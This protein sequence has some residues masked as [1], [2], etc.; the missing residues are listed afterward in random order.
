MGK[1]NRQR[2]YQRRSLAPSADSHAQAVLKSVGAQLSLRAELLSAD[3]PSARAEQLL[4]EA[5]DELSTAIA[6]FDTARVIEV[7]RLKCLPW[8]FFPQAGAAEGGL[9][10][11]EVLALLAVTSHASRGS[12]AGPTKT[13]LV[14]G[15]EAGRG[16]SHAQPIT[17]AV[18]GRI[19]AVDTILNLAQVRDLLDADPEDV[20]GLITAKIRGAEVWIRNSSYPDRVEIT[21]RELFSHE[22]VDQA[23]KARLGFGVDEALRA[24]QGCHQMQVDR[25]SA[26]T[27][28]WR[29]DM[30][31]AMQAHPDGL[32]EQE[33]SHWIGQWQAFWEPES[34]FV[35]LS[36]QEIA[37]HTGLDGAAVQAT[38]EFF[39]LDLYGSTP[40]SVIN[41]FAAGDNPL[42]TNPVIAGT[43]G[44]FMLVHDAH[45]V[46]AVREAFEQYLK[47]TP[48]WDQYQA[49][50][51]KVLEE[52]TQKALASVLPEATA[53][54]G[55]Q[56][57]VPATEA[58]EAGPVEGYTKRVEGD[59]LFVLDDVAII[60]EDKAVAV[61]PAARAGDTRRLRNDLTR[62]IERA[63]SQARRLRDRIETDQGLRLHGAEW[64]DLSSVREIHT[65]AVS[66]EDLAATT[67]GTA[68]LI[69][70]GFIDKDCIAW[71]VSLH[72]LD[73][74][75][76]LID[77]PAEFLLY[78]RRRTDPLAT[79]IYTASDELDLFLHFQQK[80]LYVEPDP[81]EL[82]NKLPCLP[83]ATAA[84][85]R[86]F[87]RQT[88]VYI[89]S[90]T[91]QLDVWHRQRIASTANSTHGA[92]EDQG[93]DFETT[94]TGRPAMVPTPLRALLEE[95]RASR[96]FAWLSIGATLLSGA[97]DAQEE[98]ARIPRDLL[99]HP[100]GDGRGRSMTIPVVD[101]RGDGWLLAWITRP[102][103]RSFDD[104]A[105]EMSIYIQ[106]KA[107]QLGMRRA[108]A[109]LY[110]E[111]TGALERTLFE[112]HLGEP[113]PEVL[114]A[115]GKLRPADAWSAKPPPKAKARAGGRST[116]KRK[117]QRSRR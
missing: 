93:V 98:M 50:R 65:I 81:D 111:A 86:R 56:Y 74:V 22:G 36:A 103:P 46:V 115:L 73:L 42:R 48:A 5:I 66:L 18:Y 76:E 34:Q 105:D 37:D 2:R 32:N 24:L 59:H 84:E 20:I 25:F 94:P 54:H 21:V 67:T 112:S 91:D 79:V 33:R 92:G 31:G 99:R 52:R 17:D 9:T 85:R 26:R 101:V 100:F 7:A 107:H 63:V 108:A 38:L 47:G 49:H 39:A 69:R 15:E 44:R 43:D 117:A 12:E 104:F 113:I 114:A 95:L 55:F 62:I 71:T 1:K 68:E 6:E 27:E 77:H 10:R 8:S 60:V 109:F 90:L 64:M 116:A 87:K 82:R 72:D 35:T 53:L 14:G 80:G 75:A 45:I 78:L 4:A 16:P 19:D 61:A 96:T 102:P 89:T 88:P 51:G 23:L 57:Y 41:A 70:A 3:D 28:R 30:T 58:E 83:A 106:A 29:D 97:T 110:D 40:R 13:E 11:A